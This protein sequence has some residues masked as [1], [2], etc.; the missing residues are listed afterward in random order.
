MCL[1]KNK[2]TCHSYSCVAW[3]EF[4]LADYVGRDP[5]AGPSAN[6]DP[7]DL[8][9]TTI[10]NPDTFK[11]AQNNGPYLAVS[12]G[13]VSFGVQSLN[14]DERDGFPFNTVCEA[15]PKEGF[16]F[17]CYDLEGD[18]QVESFQP[19]TTAQFA[20]VNCTAD[21]LASGISVTPD[22]DPRPFFSYSVTYGKE[23]FYL[24]E[25]LG[26]SAVIIYARTSNITY[27]Q[28]DVGSAEMATMYSYLTERGELDA[29]DSPTAA[30]A[31]TASPADDPTSGVSLAWK[32]NGKDLT[33]R[34]VAMGATGVT[35]AVLFLS[36][37]M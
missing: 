24:D 1:R 36:V 17:I 37:A 31:D 12:Y 32:W 19:Q 14:D 11:D 29:A 27:D 4:G 33:D 28:V 26:S 23:T 13:C 30:P 20:D 21:G 3:Y 15:Q 7:S 2:G 5:D 10:P 6:N 22:D 8:V 25:T 18:S 34:L 16:D 35:T 9:C